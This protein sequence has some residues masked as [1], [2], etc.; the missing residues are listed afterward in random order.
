MKAGAEK[1]IVDLDWLEF[2][3][4]VNG[5]INYLKETLFK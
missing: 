1:Q 2:D 4:F 5:V 3:N